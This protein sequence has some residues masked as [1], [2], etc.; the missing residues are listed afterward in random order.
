MNALI[1]YR[2]YKDTWGTLERKKLNRE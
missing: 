2:K 1:G